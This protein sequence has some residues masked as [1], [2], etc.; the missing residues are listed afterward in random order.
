MTSKSIALIVTAD[1]K[2]A[3][4]RFLNEYIEAQGFNAPVI[5]VSTK[6]IHSLKAAYSREYVCSLAQVEFKELS[7]LRRDMMM[8]TMGEG[9]ARILLD[10]YSK[11]ELA[12][13]LA[14]GGNQG[15]AI[16]SIA[17]QHLPIGI[18]K[19]IVSTVA[20][21]YVRPYVQ[22]KDIIMMFSVAD[23]LGGANTVSRTILTNAAGAVMGMCQYGIPLT[24]GSKP[25]IATTAFGNTDAAV[26]QARMILEEKGYEVIAF[27]ASG[28]SGSAME[29]LI[30]EGYIQGV[31]DMTTHELIGEVFGDDIY[32]PLR[33]RLEEAGKKGIPQVVV[34]GAIE[35]F[36]FGG[37]DTVPEKYRNR[38]THYHNPYNTNIRATKE[39]AKRT[40]EVMA[41]KLNKSNGPV[42]VMIP[43]RGFS[44][45]GRQG[46]VLYEPDTDEVFIC[47]LKKNLER[48]IQ[49][50]EIDAN[51][52]DREF[53]SKTA[54]IMHEL[55][56]KD[57][58]NK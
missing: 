35:Y 54:E 41:Q 32:T 19:L 33:P 43:L 2:E 46:N 45:N 29:Y 14:V 11:G 26:N 16:A 9:A 50:I 7:S 42:V 49:V 52:N 18:P 51:I 36:C 40:A 48:K 12:G 21:G 47:S 5:D 34:P 27:H 1:T 23:I 30:E 3:E 28:A 58:R 22:Y 38:K 57:S 37:P 31:L 55:I 6:K 24:K 10:L 25:V 4:A 8:K 53:S 39:E 13:V 17:M 56:D 44:E 20:S 15:T